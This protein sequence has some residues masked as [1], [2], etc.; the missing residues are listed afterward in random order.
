L[1]EEFLTPFGMSQSGL[2]RELRVSPRRINEIVLGKRALTADTALR[3][4]R[5]FGT[6][7]RFW[8]NSS[9]ST[10]LRSNADASVTPSSETCAH[11]PHKAR[12]RAPLW[13]L[14]SIERRSAVGR[15]RLAPR[16]RLSRR[17]D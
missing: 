4:A 8:L 11:G 1:L 9:S 2:A 5:F 15:W 6:S 12:T 10:T 14:T 13:L 7:E 3:L 17:C 16:F